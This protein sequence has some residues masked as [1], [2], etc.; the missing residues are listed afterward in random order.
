MNIQFVSASAGS[1]KTHHVVNSIEQALIS[2]ACRPGGL[3]AT[4]FTVKAAQ[5]LRERI[6]RRLYEKQNALAERIDEGLIGTVHS[7]CGQLLERFAFEAG[8]SP[9]VEIVVEEQAAALLA[10]SIESVADFGTLQSLQQIATRLGQHDRKFRFNWKSQVRD[11]VRAVQ[12]N[13]LAPAVLTAMAEQSVAELTGFLPSPAIDDLDNALLGALDT[14][15]KRIGSSEDETKGTREY[16]EF[17]EESRRE[18]ER[19]GARWS[20]WVKLAKEKPTKASLAHA[21][22]VQAV[23][24]RF[25]SHPGL[26]DDIRQYTCMVFRL[27][28]RSIAEYRRLKEER[29]LLDFDDLEQRALHLLRDVPAVRECLRQELDLLVV[30]EFQDTSPIQLGLFMSLATCARQTLWVGDIKQAI[31]GFRY[32]D[33]ELVNA[34]VAA[35]V[36]TGELAEPLGHSYRSVPDLVHLTNA[37]FIPAFGE[38]LHLPEAQIQLQPERSNLL[39]PALEFLDL[40]SGTVTKRENKPKKLKNEQFAAALTER[41]AQWLANPPRVEARNGIRSLEPRDIA[42][43]CRTNDDAAEIAAS[44]SARGLPVSLVQSGLFATPEGRLGLACLRRLADPQD[45][46][47]TAEIIAL[48]GTL[49]PEQ[50]L[51]HR[52]NYLDQLRQKRASAE[53]HVAD[54]WGAD[55]PYTHPA[56][57]AIERARQHLSA[58][59]PSEALDLALNAAD[60]F[61]TVTAWGPSSARVAERR[62]NL[63]SL[64]AL[65]R[66]FEQVCEAS[67]LAATIAGFLFWCDDLAENGQDAKGL[68]DQINAVHV[69]TYHKAKG[70]EWPMVVCTG[71]DDAPKSRLWGLA[72]VPSAPGKPFDINDPLAN[73]RLRFWAWPFGGQSDGIPLSDRVDASSAGV[74]AARVASQ[75]EL[76]LL[77]VGLTRARDL[78]VLARDPARPTPWLDLLGANWLQPGDAQV[79]LP[80]GAAIPVTNVTT[81]PPQATPPQVA[82]SQYAWFPPSVPHTERIVAR[83]IP[84]QQPAIDSAT[85]G[86]TIDLGARLPLAG[87]CDEADLGDALHSILAAEFVQPDHPMRWKSAE[88]ILHRFGLGSSLKVDDVLAAADR[89]RSVLGNEFQPKSVLVEVPFEFT[90]AAGQRAAGFLDLLLET[91]AGWIVID[92]KSFLGRR[93]DWNA[94]ALSYSGQLSCY[95]NA[96]LATG[97]R[98]AGTWIHFIARGGLLEVQWDSPQNTESFRTGVKRIS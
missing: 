82:E 60:A 55:E 85:I 33:P 31:Y 76:R 58:A 3:I 96:L 89:F 28:E 12:V 26:R 23:A 36:K 91:E 81:T 8:I 77:Y 62:A 61:A 86:R 56:I 34:V 41:V 42:V 51:E 46:L 52:L 30:D 32:S 97:R 35:V 66:K 18:L 98:C 93:E 14:C 6:R 94:K 10:Q 25:E 95:R 4:T 57:Q 20:T 87:A 37:L 54:R 2:G 72:V 63:E 5:E 68:D 90:N 59:C 92:H 9:R 48:Q 29:G 27:A 40:S 74:E 22:P 39:Q 50:W 71:F 24:A 67:H 79:S 73:R 15:I 83:L 78:L 19:G 38:A 13:D 88:Q 7:V 64:R 75:E 84:S 21:A 80:G 47:A 70:L 65:S 1:G 43:L 17:L 11:I 45:T 16:C 53:G 49:A 69:G 44:L